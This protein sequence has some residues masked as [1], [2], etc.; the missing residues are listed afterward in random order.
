[1]DCCNKDRKNRNLFITIKKYL[2]KIKEFNNEIIELDDDNFLIHDIVKVYKN[3]YNN[4][5]DYGISA[6][7]FFAN[8][9]AYYLNDNNS[10]YTNNIIIYSL[11]IIDIQFSNNNSL[12]KY[13]KY[14]QSISTILIIVSSG[15][16]I[17]VQLLGNKDKS[18]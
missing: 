16:L 17:L 12:V 5:I 9:I 11:Q 7:Y 15:L 18:T 4:L 1:M 10:Y 2:K 6:I 8:D 14:E 3:V 13:D